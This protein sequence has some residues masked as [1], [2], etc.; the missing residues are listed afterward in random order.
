MQP[1][2]HPL[3]ASKDRLLVFGS[4]LKDVEVCSESIVHLPDDITEVICGDI[5]ISYNSLI[6]NINNGRVE[7]NI[8][9]KRS[10]YP[11]PVRVP[12]DIGQYTISRLSNQYDD[13]YSHLH[14]P[15]N[16]GGLMQM[17]RDMHPLTL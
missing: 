15:Q 5:E 6:F 3:Y 12:D 9:P 1:A 13:R 16:L 7:H 17:M 4:V 8:L 10:L 2:I 11:K 14:T